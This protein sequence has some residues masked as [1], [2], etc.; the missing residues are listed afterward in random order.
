MENQFVSY[1]ISLAL[2]ELGFNERCLTC[3]SDE[4]ILQNIYNIE[5]KEFYNY[6]EISGYSELYNTHEDAFPSN[7]ETNNNYVAAPLHQQVLD[8]FREEHNIIVEV[9]YDNT[10]DDGFPWLYEIYVNN[11]EHDHEGYFYDTFKEAREE[12]ILK[13]IK[14]IKEKKL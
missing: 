12:A 9:W 11:K 7:S 8:W 5:E 1:E 14:I 10:Q 13:A 4:S 6:Y 3:Y 2:K